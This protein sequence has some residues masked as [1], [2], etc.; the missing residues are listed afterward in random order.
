MHICILCVITY[1]I[2]LII[3]LVACSC[4][5]RSFIDSVKSTVVDFIDGAKKYTKTFIV[6]LILAVSFLCYS[7]ITYNFVPHI[8][9]TK[10]IWGSCSS[11][12]KIT[13]NQN[14]MMYS[15]KAI[16]YVVLHE[17]CHLK[18]MNH[19][20]KFWAMVEKYMPDYKEA[21]KELKK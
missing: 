19:S 13:I 15:R 5:P 21:E 4:S 2:D 17:I 9:K 8:K 18:Y 12:R 1:F 7:G 11:N 10:S 6:L 14:L 20:K 3:A 16:D